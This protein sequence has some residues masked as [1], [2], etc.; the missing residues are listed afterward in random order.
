MSISTDLFKNVWMATFIVVI[1]IPFHIHTNYSRK[2]GNKL[3]H[4]LTDHLFVVV[5][6]RASDACISLHNSF[7]CERYTRDQYIKG[8]MPGFEQF[9]VILRMKE[10]FWPDTILYMST[11]AFSISAEFLFQ[12]IVHLCAHFFLKM[13]SR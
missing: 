13:L 7:L 1:H 6:E 4:G 5:G 2:K 3:F 11:C 8:L 10:F 9:C 12:R